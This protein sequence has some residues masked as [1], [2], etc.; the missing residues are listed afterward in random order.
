M[1]IASPWRQGWT[2]NVSSE[3]RL[4]LEDL[5]IET[6]RTET[7]M[8]KSPCGAQFFGPTEARVQTAVRSHVSR[9]KRSPCEAARNPPPEATPTEDP[10][11]VKADEWDGSPLQAEKGSAAK[12]KKKKK[13]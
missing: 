7:V 11:A 3:V 6:V 2:R 4:V 10:L 8:A 12:D 1:A 9:C 5:I 13:G